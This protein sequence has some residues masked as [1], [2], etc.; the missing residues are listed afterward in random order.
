MFTRRLTSLLSVTVALSVVLGLLAAC[1]PTPEPQ[2]IVETVVVEKEKEVVVTQ[3]VE[4][5]VTVEV[6]KEAA[7]VGDLKDVIMRLGWVKQA[8]YIGYY[9]ALD[10]GWF[11]EVGLNVIIYPGGADIRPAPLV[12]AGEHFATGNPNEV[13]L[14]RSNAVPLVWLY[15]YV[16][17]GF[18]RYVTKKAN[19]GI[20]D[21]Q[22]LPGHSVSLWFGGGEVEFLWC[23]NQLGIDRDDLN[24]EPQHLGMAPFLADAIDVAQ[25]TTYNELNEVFENGVPPEELTILNPNE[26]G[27]AQPGYG[28]FTRQ[29]LIDGDPQLVQ[30]FVNQ[31]IR[32]WQYSLDNPEEA[33]DILMK[34]CPE[35]DRAHQTLMLEEMIRLVTAGDAPEYGIGYTDPAIFDEILAAAEFMEILG[36]EPVN[37]DEAYDPT[38]WENVPEEYLFWEGAQ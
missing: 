15:N 7:P 38:F 32:G 4:K 10:K 37:L 9:V 1:G 18:Q 3:E 34:Y 2:T 23:L 33:M 11:E 16:E 13:L 27:C 35:C 17:E 14:P 22:D 5:V 21:W 31:S 28:L 24:M 36:P 30:D 25:V 6:E 12:A 19:T 20:E 29:S 8:E 26:A